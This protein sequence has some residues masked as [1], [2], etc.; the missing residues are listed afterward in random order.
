M[1]SKT[2]DSLDFLEHVLE[3]LDQA[4]S[5]GLPFVVELKHADAFELAEQLNALL[6]EPGV[7]AAIT[8]P[9][10]GLSGQSIDQLANGGTGTDQTDKM[11]RP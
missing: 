7:Q 3:S 4:T 9:E 10:Q 1:F 8:R 5:I 6:S 11:P 2:R